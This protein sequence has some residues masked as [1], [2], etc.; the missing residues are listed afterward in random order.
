MSLQTLPAIACLKSLQL[1]LHRRT[2]N[3][4]VRVVSAV[5]GLLE[6]GDAILKFLGQPIPLLK[7]VCERLTKGHVGKVR[8][9]KPCLNTTHC[10]NY[11]QESVIHVVRGTVLEFANRIVQ[12]PQLTKRLFNLALP[13]AAF[14]SS[15]YEDRGYD[16]QSRTDPSAADAPDKGKNGVALRAAGETSENRATHT[17][18]GARRRGSAC[19]NSFSRQIDL[20]CASANAYADYRSAISN[21]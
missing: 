9:A 11:L 1:D 20:S 8:I 12:R 16:R 13:R 3:N 7:G 5:A 10:T 4:K 21:G 2:N 19:K 15:S 6:G 17:S 18:T 14:L